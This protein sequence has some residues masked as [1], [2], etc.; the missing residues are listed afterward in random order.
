[1]EHFANLD[2]LVEAVQ[3]YEWFLGTGLDEFGRFVVYVSRM[4]YNVLKEIPAK[5]N[6]KQVLFHFFHPQH[7]YIKFEPNTIPQVEKKVEPVVTHVTQ[8]EVNIDDLISDLDDLE[9][10]CGSNVLQDIFYEVHDGKNA[11]TNWSSKFPE[12]RIAL[13]KLYSTYGFD[14]IYEEL[15]G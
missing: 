9:D 2:Q 12:V 4:D 14:L 11:V 6:N 10:I 3:K 13:D 7:T 1:M 8:E 5:I 15:D